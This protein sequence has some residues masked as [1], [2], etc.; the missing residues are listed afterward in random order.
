MAPLY[1]RRGIFRRQGEF[2]LIFP[3]DTWHH[4]IDMWGISHFYLVYTLQVFNLYI[5]IYVC[6]YMCIYIRIYIYTYIYIYV[7]YIYVYYIYIYVCVCM[8]LLKRKIP[9]LYIVHHMRTEIHIWRYPA[10][11]SRVAGTM[12][13]AT[14]EVWLGCFRVQGRYPE[15]SWVFLMWRKVGDMLT[16]RSTN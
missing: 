16:T 9:I 6:I 12:V 1:S 10:S 5:Y 11:S 7:I 2:S 15:S 8:T 3:T 13:K 14:S 4:A